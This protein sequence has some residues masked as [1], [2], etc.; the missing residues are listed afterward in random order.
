MSQRIANVA[1]PV[2]LRCAVSPGTWEEVEGLT[3]QEVAWDFS[4]RRSQELRELDP[5]RVREEFLS[6]KRGDRTGL[7]E[8]LKHTGAFCWIDYRPLS[9]D[10]IWMFQE[11]LR[12]VL[13]HPRTME[14][15]RI[16]DPYSFRDSVHRYIANFQ[17]SVTLQFQDGVLV[18]VLQQATAFDSMLS[19]IVIDRLNKRQFKIC[20]RSECGLIYELTSRHK[21]KYCSYECAHLMAVRAERVRMKRASGQRLKE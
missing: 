19:T 18:G 13:L 10:E 7:R 11:L 12:E 2:S 6:L 14:Q 9:E 17:L 8:F 1:L 15:A 21:R 20:A 16:F 5:W 4:P 3:E